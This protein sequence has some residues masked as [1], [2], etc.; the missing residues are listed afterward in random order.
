MLH[1]LLMVALL[2]GFLQL[3]MG[4]APRP[5]IRSLLQVL[6]ILLGWLLLLRCWLG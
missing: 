6:V 3:P 1:C 2:A 5:S 4:S